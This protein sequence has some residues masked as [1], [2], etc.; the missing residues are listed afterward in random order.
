[1]SKRISNIYINKQTKPLASV[2]DYICM[3][4]WGGYIHS[5]GSVWRTAIDIRIIFLNHF[6]LFFFFFKLNLK[7]AV[8]D[9]TGWTQS[10]WEIH[11]SLH[12]ARTRTT[13]MY[14]CTMGLANLNSGLQALY[15]LPG[16]QQILLYM[17]YEYSY[18]YMFLKGAL[19]ISVLRL[20]CF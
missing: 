12:G 5:W 3:M 20:Y 9:Y 15:Y 16:P 2:K 11:L 8:F 1:M 19:G 7:L 18:L 13:E 17:F 6:T 4:Y 10:L 14:H